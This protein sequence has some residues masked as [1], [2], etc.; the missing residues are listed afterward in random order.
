MNRPN[1][2]RVASAA[3]A[4]A[5]VGAALATLAV[6]PAFAANYVP[7]S[8]AGST[9]SQNAIDQWRRDVNQFGLQINYAGNGSSDGR[10]QFRSGTVDFAVSEIPYGL[11]DGGVV[12]PPP[13]KSP[14]NPRPFSYFPIV[15]GGTSIM[16]NLKIAGRQI[17][18]L[19][20]SGLTLTK[21]FT[22]NIKRWNDPAIKAD[23]PGLNLPALPVVPVVRSDGS[24]TTAQFSSYMAA[25]YPSY[26]N[27]YCV[28]GGRP[29]PCGQTSQY[30]NLAGSGFVAQA[31]SLGVAGYVA[32]SSNVG[33]ITYVEYSY[34]LNSGFP[35]AKLLNKSGYYVEP[36][37]DSVAVA[38]TG[39][40]INKDLTQNL[41]GVYNN[42]DKRAYPMSS[43]SYMIVPTTTAPPFNVD[44]GR[45]LAAF[46]AYFLCDGQNKA[47]LLG[48]SPLPLNLVQAAF[49]QVRRIP[50]ANIANINIRKCHNPTFSTSGVNTL[51]LVAPQPLPCDQTGINTQCTNGT[52]GASR[53]STSVAGLG[54]A[55]GVKTSGGTKTTPGG[56]TTT[57]GGTTTTPGGTTTTP[58]GT[59]TTPGGTSTTPGGTTTTPDGTTTNADGSTTP[60]STTSGGNQGGNAVAEPVN[61]SAQFNGS[62]ST[63]VLPLLAMLVLVGVV[64]APVIVASVLRGGNK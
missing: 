53:I 8:G 58:G 7:V 57:P 9:W 59:T 23:N 34:A 54:N 51:A 32:Q 14:T 56:T 6:Q 24:G 13:D 15:A 27:A 41:A 60:G 48:Y 50:G 10:N 12:A 30:P 49:A 61:V 22:N 17:T 2:V 62:S 26:W 19:R 42:P 31:G 1:R 63:S 52:A 29:S 5:V 4:I 45:S 64:V 11:S 37:P 16:Y 35:V 39:A 25:N 44:K 21:I 28:K 18:N 47:P 20:L 36:T 55:Y 43:Y 40:K 33:T 46:S 3:A 38:L